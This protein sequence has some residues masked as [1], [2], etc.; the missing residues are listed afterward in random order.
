MELLYFDWYYFFVSVNGFKMVATWRYSHHIS[1]KQVRCLRLCSSIG[2]SVHRFIIQDVE[3]HV[4]WLNNLFFWKKKSTC[5]IINI[6]LDGN[7]MITSTFWSITVVNL[8]CKIFRGRRRKTVEVK[9][10]KWQNYSWTRCKYNPFWI[11]L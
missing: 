10:C 2:Q 9:P 3:M 8:V 1:C 7:K 11:G 6:Y 5:E 4:R